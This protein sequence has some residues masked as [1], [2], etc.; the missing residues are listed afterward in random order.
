MSFVDDGLGPASTGLVAATGAVTVGEVTAG[1]ATGSAGG[2]SAV[3]AGVSACAAAA[4]AF[5][6]R[7]FARI[8]AV[9]GFFSSMLLLT[10]NE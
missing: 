8:S 6:A 10:R 3:I 7:I 5:W 9:E 2:I 1:A 4:A